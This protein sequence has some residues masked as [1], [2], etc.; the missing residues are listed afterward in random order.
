MTF[1]ASVKGFL[2]EKLVQAGAW[3]TLPSSQYRRYHNVTLPTSSGTTQIDHVFV[4]AFGIF[5]IETKNMAGWIFGRERD[6]V[7]TQVFRS[8][9]KYTFQNPLRQNYRHVRALEEALRA[10]GKPGGAVKSVVVFV[11]SA[12]LKRGMPENVTVGLGGSRY[13]RSFKAQVLSEAEVASICELIESQR[14]KPSWDTH[15]Q[16]IRNLESKN[17]SS[18]RSCPRCGQDMVLRTSQKGKWAGQRFWVCETYPTCRM[19]EKEQGEE[20]PNEANN[21]PLKTRP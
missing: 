18:R 10:I 20:L 13:I 2:G 19:F 3:L 6:S 11:G 9:G 7:W 15:R 1:K 12:E 14:L 16:H 21:T 17:S 4:S 5:V 8:G